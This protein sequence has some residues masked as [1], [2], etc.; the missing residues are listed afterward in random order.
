MTRMVERTQLLTDQKEILLNIEKELNIVLSQ[1][2]EIR[3]DINLEQSFTAAEGIIIGLKLSNLNISKI[4]AGVFKLGELL[5]LECNGNNLVE[6]PEE[7]QSMQK[8]A[9]LNLAD[10]R[11]AYVP[12]WIKCF[13]LLRILKLNNNLLRTLPRTIEELT[14]LRRIYLQ[15]NQIHSLPFEI[16]QLKLLEELHLDFRST[17]R[18]TIMGVLTQLEINGC[19]IKNDYN[20]R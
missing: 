16:L 7:M 6:I 19:L 5:V 8:L 20:R 17:M 13:K 2:S 12:S 15:N 14:L 9:I 11:I 4:P 18:K 1:E 10:N 3:S